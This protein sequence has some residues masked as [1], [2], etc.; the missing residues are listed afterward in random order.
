[1][2]VAPHLPRWFLLLVPILVLWN[3]AWR[4]TALWRSARRNQP[5][6]FVFLIVL[7]TVGILPIIYLLVTRNSEPSAV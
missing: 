7:N 2:P 4:G 6:W 1:M 5:V 3:L